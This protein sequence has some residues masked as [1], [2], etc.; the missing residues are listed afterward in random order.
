MNTTVLFK[1]CPKKEGTEILRSPRQVY[2]GVT[3]A[4]LNSP[5]GFITMRHE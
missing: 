3:D 1:K 2:L 5:V 4:L